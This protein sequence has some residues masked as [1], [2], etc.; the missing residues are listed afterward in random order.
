MKNAFTPISV[1]LKN[2][3]E[4]TLRSATIEDAEKLLKTVKSYIADSP[5]IPKKVSE[6][7][8]TVSQE[9]DWINSFIQKDNSLL[10]VAEYEGELVGNIDLTG[11]SRV[12]MEHTAVIG[13]GML[14]EWRALGL[15]TAL[16]EQAIAWAKENSILELLWLQVYSENKVGIHLYKKMNFSEQGVLKKYFKHHGTYYDNLTMSLM[17]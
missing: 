17:V 14:Q 3:K 13:M 16:M 12:F 11:H 10:L 7:T 5:Y 6:I 1:T 9:A 15:G 4:V 2:L 8:I